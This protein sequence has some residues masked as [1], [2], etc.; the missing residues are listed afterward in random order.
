MRV[1]QLGEMIPLQSQCK[2]PNS[3]LDLITIFLGLINKYKEKLEISECW[4]IKLMN[5][6]IYFYK[7]DY[8]NDE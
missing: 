2:I 6:R 8:D 5:S 7:L 1:A 3:L 4:N